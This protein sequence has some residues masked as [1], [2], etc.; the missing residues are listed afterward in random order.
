VKVDYSKEETQNKLTS[1]FGTYSITYEKE[2]YL[3]IFNIEGYDCLGFYDLEGNEVS[4]ITEDVNTDL[5]IK[6]VKKENI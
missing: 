4:K 6:F 1:M 5:I 2:A 3:Y